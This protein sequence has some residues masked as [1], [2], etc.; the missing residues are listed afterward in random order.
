MTLTDFCSLVEQSWKNRVFSL[1]HSKKKGCNYVVTYGSAQSNQYCRITAACCNSIRFEVSTNI[2]GTDSDF[3]DTGNDILYYLT[4][5]NVR[6]C[7]V[8]EAAKILKM[9]LRN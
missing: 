6:W 7:D 8:N 5:A 9:K 4:G 1:W 2:I 3:T